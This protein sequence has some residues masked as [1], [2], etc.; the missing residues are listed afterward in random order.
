[1]VDTNDAPHRSGHSPCFALSAARAPFAIRVFPAAPLRYVA[2]FIVPL[3]LGAHYHD[4]FRQLG[5]YPN[6]AWEVR[7]LIFGI[8]LAAFALHG[9]R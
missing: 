5:L 1:M 3:V 4:E 7:E 6:T 8:A 2:L 9:A